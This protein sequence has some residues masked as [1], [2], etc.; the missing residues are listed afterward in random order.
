MSLCWEKSRLRAEWMMVDGGVGAV[1]SDR[2]RRRDA[3]E[4]RDGGTL[5]EPR[6]QRVDGGWAPSD[7]NSLTA[8]LPLERI[9][10][11]DVT[12]TADFQG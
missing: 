2:N 6:R 3:K 5:R 8:G 4:A 1:W 12:T 10:A 7:P 9:R 11:G